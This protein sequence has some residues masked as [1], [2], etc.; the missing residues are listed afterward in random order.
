MTHGSVVGLAKTHGS[1]GFGEDQS[2][3]YT[4]C[5]YGEDPIIIIIIIILFFLLR[6]FFFFFF[7]SI[8]GILQIFGNLRKED[9]DAI[10][11]LEKHCKYGVSLRRVS[12]FFS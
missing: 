3:V 5:G 9:I 8:L 4:Q 12:A 1:H 11:S 7:F 10:F 2:I 6:V